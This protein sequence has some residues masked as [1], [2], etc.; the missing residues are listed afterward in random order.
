MHEWDWFIDVSIEYDKFLDGIRLRCKEMTNK[1]NFQFGETE[2]D[3]VFLTEQGKE[4][5]V[6]IIA[7]LEK[8]YN[9]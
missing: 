6:E 8:H 4:V 2:D 1:S 3:D 7:E 9:N 5:F